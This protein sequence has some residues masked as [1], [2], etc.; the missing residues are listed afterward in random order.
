MEGSCLRV[1][2]S[3]LSGKLHFPECCIIDNVALRNK[4][5]ASLPTVYQHQGSLFINNSWETYIAKVSGSWGFQEC[6]SNIDKIFWLEAAV[7]MQ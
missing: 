1:P 7:N 3:S 5:P 2:V 4:R 6:S